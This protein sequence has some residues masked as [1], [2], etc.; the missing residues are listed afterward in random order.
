[1]N[2]RR[3]SRPS[4]S[5]ATPRHH[6]EQLAVARAHRAGSRRRTSRH[7]TRQCRPGSPDHR[8]MCPCS[9]CRRRF[10]ASFC[11]RSW[12]SVNGG[13]A[14]VQ[15][16]RAR[17]ERLGDASTTQVEG[18]S[19]RAAGRRAARGRSATTFPWDSSTPMK[20]VSAAGDGY[21]PP[22]IRNTH[23]ISASHD[24]DPRRRDDAAPGGAEAGAPGGACACGSSIGRAR[25]ASTGGQRGR[26]HVRCRPRPRRWPASGA[27]ES[28]RTPSSAPRE[29]GARR[30][31]RGVVT[32][33]PENLAYCAV[34]SSSKRCPVARPPV[35]RAPR[36]PTSSS[37]NR[38]TVMLS[39]PPAALAA[40]ISFCAACVSPVGCVVRHL[41]A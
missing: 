34:S 15:R 32:A 20:H 13:A 4:P 27:A 36:P 12:W 39:R 14:T 18:G 16:A 5:T 31:W 38:T 25:G 24:E 23:G 22:P 11:E 26:A 1:M 30:P 28:S 7:C 19:H 40:S 9:S 2:D 17:R 37:W 21:P 6:R 10:S 35:D 33:S 3:R 41:A 8:E 29:P